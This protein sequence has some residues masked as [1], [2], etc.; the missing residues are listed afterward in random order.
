M[1]V[2]SRKQK[3]IYHNVHLLL[4]LGQHALVRNGDAFEDMMC[5]VIDG[6][7]GSDEVDVSEAT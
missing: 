6:L 5:S 3:S 1:R 4:D 2:R 7:S